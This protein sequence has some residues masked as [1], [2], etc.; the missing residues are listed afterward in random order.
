M[1]ARAQPAS[2]ATAVGAYARG[3]PFVAASRRCPQPHFKLCERHHFRAVA[4]LKM[5]AGDADFE[6]PAMERRAGIP[7]ARSWA[8]FSS[9]AAGA[10]PRC[11]GADS[12][13]KGV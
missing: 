4:R 1:P 12:D 5:L 7:N 2:V 3:R 13:R 8:V 6:A 10:K 9:G 11:W